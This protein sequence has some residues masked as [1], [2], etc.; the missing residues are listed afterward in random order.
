MALAPVYYQNYLLGEL[1]ASQ[2]QATLFDRFGGIVGRPAAGEF[3][4]DEFFAP[5]WSC[6]WDELVARATG[7]PL[8]VDAYAA[9]LADLATR[10]VELSARAVCDTL[11]VVG[12]DGLLF[13]K[14]SDRPPDEP[15]V[16]ERFAPRPA[17]G[18]VRTQYL[19]LP[20]PGAARVRRLP[21]RRGCG[22]S[23]TASTS[24]ASRSATRSSTRPGDPKER[25][26][27]LLGMD[28]V[29]LGLERGRSADAR[30]RG[31]DRPDRDARAGRLGR[32]RTRT[33]RTTRR[34]SSPTPT[35]GWIVETC[36]RTWAARPIG[37]GASVSNRISLGT[38][39]TRASADV[40]AG[41]R[42]P[43][44]PA[45][46]DPHHDRRPPPRRH[47]ALRRPRRGGAVADAVMAA[48]RD[49][50]TGPW[51]GPGLHAA[52][53]PPA[54]PGPDHRG[55]TVCMHVRGQQN[56]TASMVVEVPRPAARRHPDPGRPR[57][58]LRLG[59][60]PVRVRRV[61]CPTCSATRPR[62][63]ASPGSAIVSSA[64]PDAIA[65][66]PGPRSRRSRRRSPPATPDAGDRRRGPHDP[67][68]LTRTP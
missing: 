53:P 54:E 28:L 7:A 22:A 45:P 1:V 25:P 58:S 68:G 43:G 55:V 36:D 29:R 10:A 4:R 63:G 40:A 20:D 50:G 2:L 35:G 24:T 32:A 51:G 16:V 9:E 27:A 52:V 61:R 6:R 66:D 8:G 11:A 18:T 33:R 48:L 65:G 5:G 19:E 31:H 17:G 14:N 15:Q 49:H 21:A 57:Q 13:G 34:S 44:V 26:P 39:W 41:H 64:D 62:G 67:R 60:R 38:D 56:T 30:G 12:A 59:L 47:R 3:L 37:A 42:L 23:S 46:R